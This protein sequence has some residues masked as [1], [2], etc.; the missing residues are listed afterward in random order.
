[1]AER[2]CWEPFLIGPAVYVQPFGI[3]E[4]FKASICKAG[5][6]YDSAQKMDFFSQLLVKNL[7]R[8]A[9]LGSI[10]K[11]QGVDQSDRVE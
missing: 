9:N 5:V 10:A 2:S 3:F 1:M 4:L 8:V 11:W 6:L 7:V